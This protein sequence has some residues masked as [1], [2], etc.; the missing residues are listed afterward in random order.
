[1]KTYIKPFLI[2]PINVTESKNCNHSGYCKNFVQWSVDDKWFQHCLLGYEKEQT[3][4]LVFPDISKLQG[5][6]TI[7]MT[8]QCI[9][10]IPTDLPN[11]LTILSLDGNEIKEIPNEL[12]N[13]LIF[14]SLTRNRIEEIPITLPNSLA[15]LYLHGNRIKEIQLHWK[16][17][18]D[19]NTKLTLG[20]RA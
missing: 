13:S 20:L 8:D 3:C 1:M 2:S 16:E 17:P 4:I 12:P 19:S 18:K 15:Q 5:V 6:H 10:R 9:S 14:L 7:V 11:S